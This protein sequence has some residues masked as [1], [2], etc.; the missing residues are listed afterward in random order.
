LLTDVEQPTTFNVTISQCGGPVTVF[1]RFSDPDAQAAT[2]N[3][4]QNKGTAKGYELKLQTSGGDAITFI[5][6][7]TTALNGEINLGNS[8]TRTT[9]FSALLSRTSD[10]VRPGTLQFATI[11]GISYR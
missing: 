6:V 1:A 7:G 10:A 8:Q 2:K 5:P 4:L 9:P 11:V 3:A